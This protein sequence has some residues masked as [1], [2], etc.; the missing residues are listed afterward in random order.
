VPQVVHATENAVVTLALEVA[1]KLV[2][3]LP[4]SPVLVEAAVR[5]AMA[6]VE[7]TTELWIDLH[8]EDLALLQ[9][10]ESPLLSPQPTGPRLHFQT[11]SDVSHGGC[12]VR[13]RF[14]VIDARRETKVELLKQSLLR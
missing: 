12:V 8:P 4:V 5:E 7:D 6:L 2:A 3:G 11:S 1:Q 9:Q 10:V 13:T 14:G